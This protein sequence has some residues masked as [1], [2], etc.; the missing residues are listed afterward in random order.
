M[1]DITTNKIIMTNLP[2]LLLYNLSKNT[3]SE[4]RKN[5]NIKIRNVKTNESINIYE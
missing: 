5:N 4:N 3:W 1:I 2:T